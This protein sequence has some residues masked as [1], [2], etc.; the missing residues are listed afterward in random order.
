MT[1]T[2]IIMLIGGFL[3]GLLSCKY[4][5]TDYDSA[6]AKIKSWCSWIIARFKTPNE[7]KDNQD[8]KNKDADKE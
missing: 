6:I 7:K 2:G 3:A 1:I 8:D 5:V 4:K